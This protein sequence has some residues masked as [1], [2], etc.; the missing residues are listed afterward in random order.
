[1]IGRALNWCKTT[2]RLPVQR[3]IAFNHWRHNPLA[4]RCSHIRHG[5]QKKRFLNGRPTFLGYQDRPICSPMIIH[6]W[7]SVVLSI[8]RSRSPLASITL[9]PDMTHFVEIRV[10]TNY[11]PLNA[12][13]NAYALHNTSNTGAALLCPR[14]LAYY[15]Y[16]KPHI[17]NNHCFTTVLHQ[18]GDVCSS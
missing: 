18:I 14:A 17:P 16:S 10:K 3:L 9:I 7:V 8:N 2:Y 6:W 13:V 12:Y 1:M 5:E 11:R 4:K 15:V